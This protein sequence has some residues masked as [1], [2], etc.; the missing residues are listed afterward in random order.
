MNYC[1]L[2]TLFNKQPVYKQ[3]D[4]GWQIAKQLSGLKCLIVFLPDIGYLVKILS[5]HWATLSPEK[6]E[7]ISNFEGWDLNLVAYMR[8]SIDCNLKWEIMKINLLFLFLVFYWNKKGNATAW[9]L[10]LAYKFLQYF[11]QLT[12][13]DKYVSR[14]RIFHF[15]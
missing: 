4:L 9:S 6:L 8:K 12:R 13:N 3:L 5:N 14:M 7:N 10:E 2:N 11:H 1:F 15:K